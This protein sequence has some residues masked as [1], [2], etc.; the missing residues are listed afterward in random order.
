MK[1]LLIAV[2]ATSCA[3]P[4]AP[5]ASLPSAGFTEARGTLAQ[6]TLTRTPS[7]PLF[8]SVVESDRAK[9]ATWSGLPGF[10]LVLRGEERVG[11]RPLFPGQATFVADGA[12]VDTAGGSAA[13]FVSL[14]ASS[15]RGRD[16]GAGQRSRYASADLPGSA[17]PAGGYSDALVLLVMQPGAVIP[18][19]MHGGVEPMYVVEGTIELRV[20][21]RGTKRLGPGDGDTVLPDTPLLVTNVGS[22]VA[23]VVVMLA[24]P[25][26]KPVQTQTDAP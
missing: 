8:V 17:T 4:L 22:V 20:A 26:G 23:R 24:T 2:L 7:E 1:W 16:L 12:T 19:H 25:D 5:A 14:R 9:G 18:P 15:S 3:A 21:G 13:L 6:A 11:S 10:E